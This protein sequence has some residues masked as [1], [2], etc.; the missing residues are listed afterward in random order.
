MPEVSFIEV[1]G[2]KGDIGLITLDRPQALNAL[3][4][5]MITAISAQL[6]VWATSPLIKAV[7]IHSSNRKAFCAGGDI[8]AI[9]ELG[10]GDNAAVQHFFADEY[11]LNYQ[12]ATYPKPYVALLNGIT[13]GGGAGLSLH[14]GLCLATEDLIFAMPETGIGFFPD[15]G[16]SYFLSRCPDFI[17]LYL[18]LT[19]AR[20]NAAD[21][22]SIGL[23]P[24]IIAQE[25]TQDIIQTMAKHPLLGIADISKILQPYFIAT[26]SSSLRAIRHE[27]KQHFAKP[28]LAAIIASLKTSNSSFAQQ[29]LATLASRSPT[30]LMVFWEAFTRGSQYNLK[31]CLQMEYTIM[32]QFLHI[33]DLYEGIR[34]VL[35]EKD[36][37]PRWDPNNISLVSDIMLSSFFTPKQQEIL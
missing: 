31:S 28:S 7:I 2:A 18:G 8:R 20:I 26:I 10:R 30:S 24:H 13:M 32:Q 35:I 23:I 16:A 6:T 25:S 5:A 29:T 14:G 34:A 22:S 33:P 1:P 17:G 12:I 19:G 9:Y 36:F 3:N 27:I 37:Q 21:V 4:H 11:R 15:V